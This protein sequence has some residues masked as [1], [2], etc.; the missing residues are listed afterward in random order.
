MFQVSLAGLGWPETI[1]FFCS[2]DNFLEKV[3]EILQPIKTVLIYSY[4]FMSLCVV[5]LF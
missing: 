3:D 1:F 5:T 2:G 4:I